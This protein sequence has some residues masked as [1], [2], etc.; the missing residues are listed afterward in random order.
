MLATEEAEMRRTVIQSQP[1]QIVCK[2]YLKKKGGRG[3]V[4]WLKV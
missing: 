2:T 4:E 3:L 1:E